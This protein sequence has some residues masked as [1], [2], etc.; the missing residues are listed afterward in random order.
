MIGNWDFRRV[1][2]R[3]RRFYSI[4]SGG[5]GGLARP[6]QAFH[7]GMRLGLVVVLDVGGDRAKRRDNRA[8]VITIAG[9]RE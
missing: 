9:T 3:S 4:N 7:L 1:I 6:K 5:G 8:P 2:L